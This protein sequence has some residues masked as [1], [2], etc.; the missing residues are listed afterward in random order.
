MVCRNPGC[1][2]VTDAGLRHAYNK[3]NHYEEE[4]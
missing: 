4:F 2:M 3:R 1:G